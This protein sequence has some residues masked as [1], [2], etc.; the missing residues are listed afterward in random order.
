M[1]A[2][3]HYSR[4]IAQRCQNLIQQLLPIINE[5]L[6]ND[7]QFG[8]PLRTTFLLAMAT[9]MIVLPIERIFK[10]EDANAAHA[11]NDGELD[12]TLADAVAGVLGGERPFRNAPFAANVKWSYMHDCRP[13]NIAGDWPHEVLEALGRQ[14]AIDAARN[15]PA[16][17]ILLDLRNA[18]A[19]GGVTY[20]DDDGRNTHGQAAM[21]AFAG[22]R[23]RNRQIVGLNILRVHEEDFRVFLAAWAE[24]LTRTPVRNALNN[25]NPEEA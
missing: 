13:F 19:H 22:A 10:P 20:L 23:T 21:F 12:A 1:T 7:A 2:P 25:R 14:E 5:G 4:E 17:R 15:A 8:G 24:W 18:L 9:P 6:P 3:N 11:A 16:S